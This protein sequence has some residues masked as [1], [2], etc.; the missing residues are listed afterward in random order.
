M[1]YTYREIARSLSL[2]YPKARGVAFRAEEKVKDRYPWLIHRMRAEIMEVLSCLRNVHDTRP[3]RVLVYRERSFG[4]ER[5]PVTLR[6]R[7]EGEVPEDLIDEPGRL[8]RSLPRL[9]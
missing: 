2:P 1:A 9:L 4:Y 6:P 3:A 5:E 7:P 8:L